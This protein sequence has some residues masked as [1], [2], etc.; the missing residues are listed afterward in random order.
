MS[1]I[2][3]GRFATFEQAQQAQ[4]L[5]Q[6]R[7][8][9]TDDL[10]VFYVNP[11]GRHDMTAV[12]G[13]QFADK[14]TRKSTRGVIVGAVLGALVGVVIGMVAA[15]AS[16]RMQALIF[17]VATG[18]G[19]YAGSLIGALTATAKKPEAGSEPVPHERAAGVM[20]AARV[21]DVATH[22]LAIAAFEQ[23][24]ALDIEHA[25]GQWDHGEWTDFNPIA[26]PQLEP[27]TP[28][29]RNVSRQARVAAGAH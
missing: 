14:G 28:T 6:D 4:T 12:G 10:S 21:V 13:D 1:E 9:A 16:T 29:H 18:I 23:A 11:P 27:D 8:F 5:L 25:S 17:I 24:A 22:D 26:P 2:I 15:V 3:A 19:A 7:G 20:L